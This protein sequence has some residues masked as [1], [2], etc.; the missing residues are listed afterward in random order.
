LSGEDNSSLVEVI[1][2][3]T[4]ILQL[5]ERMA[6]GADTRLLGGIP[7]FDSLAVA[8]VV[9]GLEERFGLE[10]DDEDISAELFETFGTLAA[11]V[12]RSRQSS[13]VRSDGPHPYFLT[14]S[15]GNL[16]VIRHDA[17]GDRS[18]CVVF[19]APFAEE[20]NRVREILTSTAQELNTAGLSCCSF[21]FH[22]T[23]D[24]DGEFSDARW[25]GWL[26]D[27]H[28]VVKSLQSQGFQTIDLIGVRLGGLLAAEYIETGA[29]KIGRVVVWD[30]V[31][32]S[33]K[34]LDQFLRTRS[35]AAMMAGKTESVKDLRTRLLAGNSVEVAGYELHPELASSL[36]AR[37]PEK[38]FAPG[39]TA[40]YWIS[41]DE[42]VQA[43]DRALRMGCQL[44]RTLR[45]AY[46]P[47]WASAETTRAPALTQATVDCLT[48]PVR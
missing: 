13:A 15:S 4:R 32:D 47:Y 14:T 24:S 12:D 10:F 31:F 3:L 23:G 40:M 6:L 29:T 33:N 41:R 43:H 22:G 9:I 5:D 25:S 35:M 18:R 19:V 27:L 45:P 21:D 39:N 28:E 36:A 17:P 7:E 20:M 44:I 1:G 46:E 34:Y 37:G 11:F 38:R 8:S 2:T 30:P 42:A 26:S 48:G 16:Y